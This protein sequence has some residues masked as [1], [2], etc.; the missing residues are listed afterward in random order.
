M[1]INSLLSCTACET[2]SAGAEAQLRSRGGTAAGKESWEHIKA[3]RQW[4]E[5]WSFLMRQH[6]ADVSFPITLVW[7]YCNIYGFPQI[8]NWFALTL[9]LVYVEAQSG[10]SFFWAHLLIYLLTHIYFI[11]S[12][13][14]LFYNPKQLSKCKQ[15]ITIIIMI[16]ITIKVQIINITTNWG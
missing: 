4:A 6:S 15:P 2:A 8:A 7:L 10:L 16:N 9:A 13:K 1:K 12:F 5:Y 14:P 11:F 3:E